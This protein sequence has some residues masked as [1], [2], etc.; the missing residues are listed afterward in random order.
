MYRPIKSWYKRKT[1]QINKYIA[2]WVPEHP[3]SFNGGW[4]YE[5]RLVVERELGRILNE[6]ETIH[7]IDNNPANNKI[8]NLF[9]CTGT[10]HRYAHIN[11]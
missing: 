3:K 4:Y 1:K 10:E 6:W 8:E 7:H 2:V 9:P 5:H 11:P